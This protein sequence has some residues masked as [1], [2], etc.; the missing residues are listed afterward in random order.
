MHE[1]G[2]RHKLAVETR[3]REIR[4]RGLDEDNRAQQEDEWVKRME[5]N[6]MKDYR[7]KDLESNSD[8]TA[9][10]FNEKRAQRDAVR[11]AE[12][13][14]QEKRDEE[15]R[16]VK[17]NIHLGMKIVPAPSTSHGYI[18]AGPDDYG[19]P[20]M[21]RCV[22][23][24]KGGTKWH[25]LPPKPKLWF[26]AMSE[27]G[28]KYFWN[29]ETNE[30]R[31]DPPPE[32]YTSIAEQ[33]LMVDKNIPM[34]RQKQEETKKGPPAK[35]RR[36]CVYDSPEREEEPEVGPVE[37]VN[38]YGSWQTVAP[39]MPSAEIDYQAPDRKELNLCSVTLHSESRTQFEEKKT[40]SLGGN[41]SGPGVSKP[42]IV[43]RKRKAPNPDAVR[44]REDET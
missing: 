4:R 16:E 5:E 44:K 38:P 21:I 15:E 19:K 22:Q 12:E 32:G 1:G 17:R 11:D 42:A 24:P 39:T 41:V 8:L 20:S 30:S 27:N 31:W 29:T 9:K 7:M 28:H 3:L 34:P 6:A 10:I 25:N 13:E 2:T 23:A 18:V 43:F 14:E 37:R 36:P 33:G 35:I 40:P 26:E